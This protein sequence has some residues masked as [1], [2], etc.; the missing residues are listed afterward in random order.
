MCIIMLQP[1]KKQRLSIPIAHSASA[2]IQQTEHT[3]QVS[4][5]V[6]CNR[7]PFVQIDTFTSMLDNINKI[8]VSYKHCQFQ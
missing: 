1:K 3:D 2:E 6:N 4:L 7:V 8:E 5:C